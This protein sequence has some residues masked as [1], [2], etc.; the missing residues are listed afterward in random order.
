MT[1]FES[2]AFSACFLILKV[3]IIG[4][5]T[6]ADP[7]KETKIV[8]AGTKLQTLLWAPELDERN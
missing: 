3:R 1:E 6:M 8:S 7:Y 5:K 2:R 4:F